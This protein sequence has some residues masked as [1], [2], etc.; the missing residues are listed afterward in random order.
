MQ[1]IME[2]MGTGFCF[3]FVLGGNEGMSPIAC[4]ARMQKKFDDFV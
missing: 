3:S 1:L 4:Q 2:I